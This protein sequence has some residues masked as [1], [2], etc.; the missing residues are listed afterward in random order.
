MLAVEGFFEEIGDRQVRQLWNALAENDVSTFMIEKP[1]VPHIT[2]GG[3]LDHKFESS[4]RQF[5]S[6][7]EQFSPTPVNMPYLGLFTSPFKVIFLGVTVTDALHNLHRQFYEQCSDSIDWNLLYVPKLWIPHCTLAFQLDDTT[8]LQGLD[9][10]CQQPLPVETSIN[11]LAI[12]EST[13]GE[14]LS[15]VILKSN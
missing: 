11:R 12:V 4:K 5:M 2:L 10:C 1:Y 3:I 7:A 9:I 14:I 6:F 15:S 8:L 13:T